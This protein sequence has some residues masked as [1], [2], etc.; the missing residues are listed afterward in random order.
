MAVSFPGGN[1]PFPRALLRGLLPD[2]LP[3][4]DF[5]T[6]MYGPMN[7]EAL[8]RDDQSVRIRLNATALRVEHV[9]GD[10][11]RD[12]LAVTYERDGSLFKVGARL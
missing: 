12:A 1:S 3:G 2:S 9:N 10:H 6:L 11:G 5:S 8:D 7:F 4:K